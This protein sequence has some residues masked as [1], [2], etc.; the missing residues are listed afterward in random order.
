MSKY[1]YSLQ[2]FLDE[3]L[4]IS[5]NI[6]WKNPKLALENESEVFSI[7]VEQFM[8]ASRGQLVF[9]TVYKF[10]KEALKKAGVDDSLLDQYSDNMYLIPDN[11]REVCAKAQSEYLLEHYEEH[12]NYYRMLNGLPDWEDTDFFYNTKYP[13][14]GNDRIPIH[15]L[16]KDALFLL[17]AEGYLDELINAH[18]DKPYLKHL[19]DRKIGFYTARAANDFGI[20]WVMKSKYSKLVSD[21]QDT[22]SE[23]REMVMSLY[24]QK[25][26]QKSNSEYIGFIGITI[27]F[28]TLI[29]MNRKVLDTDITRDFYDEQSLQYVYDSYGV[30]YYDQ[31]PITYHRKIVQ[32]INILIS[33]KG[34]NQVFY[35][36]FNI[37]GFSSIDLYE[38]FIMKVHKF[39]DGNP[40]FVKTKE[41]TPDYRSMYEYKFAK[42]RLYDNPQTEMLDPQNSIPYERITT[43]DP[44]WI[45]DENLKNYLDTQEFNYMESKYF[46]IQTTFNLMR[47][48]Y[49]SCYFLT[50][51][52]NNRSLLQHTTIYYNRIHANV[53]IYDMVIYLCAMYMKKN[54]FSGNIPR[55]IHQIG[56]VMGFNFVE[57]LQVIRSNIQEDDYLKNDAHLLD[58]LE[59]TSPT[60]IESIN[61]IFENLTELRSYLTNKMAETQD[62]PTYWAYYNLYKTIMYSKYAEDAF[63]LQNGEEATSFEELLK[64]C[65]PDLYQRFQGDYE[66]DNEFSSILYLFESTFTSLK[67]FHQ[68]DMINSNGLFEYIFKLLEFFKSAK[69]E[70]IGYKMVYSLVSSS[71]NIMKLMSLITFIHDDHTS[72]PQK[73]FLVM[74]DVIVWIHERLWLYDRFNELTSK[75]MWIHDVTWLQD[76]IH[77]LQDEIVKVSEILYGF[78][79]QDSFYDDL[80]LVERT[81]LTEDPHVLSDDLNLMYDNVVEAL[82]YFFT[83]EYPYVLKIAKCVESLD[84]LEDRAEL[85]SRLC[86]SEFFRDDPNK[87]KSEYTLT[88][89][90]IPR[91]VFYKDMLRSHHDWID[92]FLLE[93]SKYFISE[94]TQLKEELHILEKKVFSSD[95]YRLRDTI[96]SSKQKT[97]IKEN[98][99][100]TDQ[101]FLIYEVKEE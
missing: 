79:S 93:I 15:L 87:Q 77:F 52:L 86:I 26:M 3:L 62:V 20:L 2:V 59:H 75:I 78:I 69:T 8:L 74:H 46:G 23:C 60:S 4:K 16:D 100:M 51:I 67:E 85:F 81:Y 21:F 53:N 43:G 73:M 33:N 47:L 45:E 94:D 27:L 10:D 22:Y 18:P 7:S 25:D 29:Q 44:Y 54:G 66:W 17:E 84:R 6:I 12:N 34:S 5:S 57:D 13:D 83:E 68:L 38:Y 64:D 39:Q 40:V 37:F 97:K 70:L 72:D 65:N 96:P 90:L 30:P 41:G 24:Y 99:S 11:L 48:M 92:R 98:G 61:E 19:T 49:E 1:E 28:A 9:D 36:L 50:M 42:V 82:K 88:D 76:Q 55:H 63:Q 71:E 31:I 14:I 80:Q 91:T 58:L 101:L 32:N 35:D 95:Y 56:K 89:K